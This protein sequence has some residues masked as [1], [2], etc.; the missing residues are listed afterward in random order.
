MKYINKYVYAIT[1]SLIRGTQACREERIS[2]YW[3]RST[4][5]WFQISHLP[6]PSPTPSSAHPNNQTEDENNGRH[7][8]H[9]PIHCVPTPVHKPIVCMYAHSALIHILLPKVR[10]LRT[11]SMETLWI[12]VIV[13]SV[14]WNSLVNLFPAS[15]IQY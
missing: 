11:D 15:W 6:S 10:N 9:L 5:K 12:Q 8:R 2:R 1:E 14:N 13:N 7:P 4:G 3:L